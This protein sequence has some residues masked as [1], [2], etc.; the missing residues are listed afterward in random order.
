M[1]TGAMGIHLL[2]HNNVSLK[3]D[4]NRCGPGTTITVETNVVVL[5]IT[6]ILLNNLFRAVNLEP[7]SLHE[8][9]SDRDKQGRISE[10]RRS[11][12]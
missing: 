2:R 12:T 7:V 10:L 1:S 11:A 9:L 8:I 5:N 4:P 3:E 6:R